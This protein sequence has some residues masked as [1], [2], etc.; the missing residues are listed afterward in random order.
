M[1]KTGE[2]ATAFL[3]EAEMTG[4]NRYY[5]QYAETADYEVLHTFAALCAAD[6]VFYF[7]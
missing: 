7:L 4:E 3:A 1:V 5:K 2:S 6:A